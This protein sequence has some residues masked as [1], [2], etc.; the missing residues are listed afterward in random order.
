M[1][2]RVMLFLDYQ[3]V[4]RG[5]RRT[6]VDE[7]IAHHSHGQIHPVRLGEL[8][9]ETSTFDRILEG[10]R[11]YRGQPDATRDP[12]GYAACSRQI[13]TWRQ[14]DRVNV[15]SRTL[16]YPP[17]WSTPSQSGEKPQEKGIDVALAIDFVRLAIEDRY[18]VGILMSTDTDLKPAL[19]FV[20]DRGRAWGKL[21]A[22]VAAWSTPDRQCRRLSVPKASL[23]CHWLD[24]S[25]YN[26]VRDLT[27][28]AQ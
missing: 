8:L 12:K 15:T 22:E 7:S 21:R 24:Q 6:F 26:Q 2:D 9:V 28:Y 5:A 13:A 17:G 18:D 19:E 25:M 10:V 23:W 1:A 11:V 4:Y 27:N 3:N 14:D 20:C 16:K